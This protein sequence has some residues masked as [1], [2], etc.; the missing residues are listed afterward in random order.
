MIFNN[1]MYNHKTKL[2]L[3]LDQRNMTFT[4]HSP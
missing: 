4:Q 3:Q 1:C 2:L